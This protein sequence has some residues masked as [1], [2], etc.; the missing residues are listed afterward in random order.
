[1][2]SF[3]AY[4][5]AMY[6]KRFSFSDQ[7]SSSRK[8]LRSGFGFGILLSFVVLS[9]VLY[10]A[11]FKA[12][13]LNPVFWNSVGNSSGSSFLSWPFSRRFNGVSSPRDVNY[14][15]SFNDSSIVLKS[16]HSDSGV[17]VGNKTTDFSNS[18]GEDLGIQDARGRNVSDDFKGGVVSFVGE[19]N[20]EQKT[21]GKKG[22][23]IDNSTMSGATVVELNARVG[24]TTENV[25]NVGVGIGEKGRL[26]GSEGKN[27]SENTAVRDAHIQNGGLSDKE[28]NAD[29]TK[30]SVKT[31]GDGVTSYKDCDIYD[32]RWVKDESKPYYPP[33][34]CPYID[35]DFECRLNGRPDSEYMKWRWQPNGCDIPRF[36][37]TDFLERLRGQTLVFVGDSLNRNMWESL[38]CMLRH[39]VPDK[40]RVYEISGRHEFKKKGFYAFRF[41]DY[42]CSV[43]FVSSPFLV[44]ESSFKG[45][46]GTLET[47]RLDLMDTTTS[48]YRDAD[49]LIFNTG[50][51]WTHEKTA[52]GEDYY[53]EGNYVHPRLKVLDAFKRALYTWGKWVDK[54]IDK[55]KS[56]IIFRGYSVTHFRYFREYKFHMQ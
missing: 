3:S 56:F 8:Q 26:G 1:M 50:H 24:N 25:T 47:L 15:S 29:M 37:S 52:R 23:P 21:D 46:N 49:I 13:F 10:N 55:T 11:S 40:K 5:P 39:G 4:F 12:P 53:Q 14:T 27:V 35:R 44:K 48:M 17:L 43:D 20:L 9:V 18:A 22:S 33:G 36:N 31:L 54:N 32:G 2:V 42:N 41:E 6:L 7:V 19:D 45:K 16:G 51:W 30:E 34:S 28:G 38:V